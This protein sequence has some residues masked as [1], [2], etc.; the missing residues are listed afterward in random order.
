MWWL[1]LLLPAIAQAQ[2]SFAGAAACQPCHP[3]H[4]DRQIRSHHARSLRRIGE[5]DLVRRFTEAPLRERG[6]TEFSYEAVPGGIR[7]VARR[8]PDRAE[9]LLEWA[10]GAGSQGITP[11]GR[12]DG[13]YIEHRISYYTRAGRPA[14]TVG[15]P[16]ASSPDAR[17]ALGMVQ[18]PETIA[19]CFSCHATNVQP[20]P[21]LAAMHSGVQCERCHGP[22]SAHVERPGSAKLL[23]AG[24]LPAK[25]SVQ[26]CGE[27]HRAPAPGAASHM[28]EVD[29]PVSIRFQPIG[30]MASRCFEQSGKLTCLTCH[31]PHEDA[32][33]RSDRFYAT[34]CLSCHASSSKRAQ[35]CRRQTQQDCLPCHMQ[36]SSPLPYLTFTDHRIRV[37]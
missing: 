3:Q 13:R 4:Y 6:G 8:G 5:T 25:A 9:A 35:R 2:S 29:D 17:S 37:H 23:N 28:P 32:R 10:F 26:V 36:S 18:S 33:P 15:H 34:Q 7:A 21:D 12:I 30:L 20:G 14:R 11:V 19:R 22:A 1:L 16:G 27:C 24:R 31:D